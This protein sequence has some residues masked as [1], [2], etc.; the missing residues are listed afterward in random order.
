[1]GEP[2]KRSARKAF[3]HEPRLRPGVLNN[4]F[5]LFGMETKVHWNN[6]KPHPPTGK[7]KLEIPRMVDHEQQHAIAGL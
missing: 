7:D 6:D 1:M 2:M 4:P 3:T 5:D